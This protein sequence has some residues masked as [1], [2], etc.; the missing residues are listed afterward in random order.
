MARRHR[1]DGKDDLPGQDSFVDI[2]ANMVGILIL[3]VVIVGI[4]AAATTVVETS[5]AEGVASPLVTSSEVKAARLEAI[6]AA[7]DTIE[8]N[9][10]AV[11]L[12]ANAEELDFEREKLATYVTAAKE[13]LDR[14]RD[15]LAQDD[16]QQYDLRVALISAEETLDDL[17]RKQMALVSAPLESEQLKNVPTPLA[18]QVEGD[19][20][21][22]RVESG[23]VAIVPVDA[24]VSQLESRG[25]N[26]IRRLESRR[27]PLGRIGPMGGFQMLYTLV[28]RQAA[29]PNGVVGTMHYLVAEIR[30]TRTQRGEPVDEAVGPDSLLM[31][32]L[33]RRDPRRTS[34]TLWTYP[35]S[36]EEVTQLR[37]ALYARGFATAIRPLAK[38]THIGLSPFGSKSR[39]Q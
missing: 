19:E 35:D 36:F 16:Q 14:R 3:L 18:R 17:T 10:K 21:A 27:D 30:P 31:E 2:I 26:E 29:R 20:V 37:Q 38:G 32:E 25:A 39:A 13:E 7:R 1:N 15:A 12:A 22:L 4:G 23:R 9:R 28:S 8:L 6:A 24:F 33:D 34:V 5:P 11:R